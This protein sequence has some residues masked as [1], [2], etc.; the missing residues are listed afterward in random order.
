MQPFA[1]S[2]F[3]LVAEAET[4]TPS[5]AFHHQFRGL[6][7][8]PLVRITTLDYGN[9]HAV[10]AENN[11]GL[12]R[13]RE[14]G[15]RLIY[16]FNQGIQILSMSIKRLDR[17]HRPVIVEQPFPFVQAAAGGRTRVLGIER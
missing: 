17:V 8:L 10:S 5:P 11:L 12:I 16:F 14:A 4:I 15:Q 6:C 13:V 7:N 9:R 1:G 3:S 2:Y